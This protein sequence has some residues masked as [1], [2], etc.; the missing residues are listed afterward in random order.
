[1]ILVRSPVAPFLNEIEDDEPPAEL[2]HA[3]ELLE[4]GRDIP[5]MKAPWK[6]PMGDG[7][8]GERE[9]PMAEVRWAP[10]GAILYAFKADLGDV[11]SVPSAAWICDQIGHDARCATHLRRIR[12]SSGA[13]LGFAAYP[14]GPCPVV[15]VRQGRVHKLTVE[16]VTSAKLVPG[17]TE[18]VLLLTTRWVRAKGH[19]TG[20]ALVP[21]ALSTAAPKRLPE[22]PIDEVDARDAAKV[23]SR[24]VKIQITPASLG[25]SRI[26]VSGRRR[27]VDRSDGRELASAPIEEERLVP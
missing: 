26:R 17:G 3:G 10:G 23:T 20:G 7:T 24:E 12:L 4:L 13:V 2:G 22:I 6:A 16:G 27:V 8:T 5:A 19:W 25:H 15:V 21:V 1:M 9:G 14:S 11:I 18:G